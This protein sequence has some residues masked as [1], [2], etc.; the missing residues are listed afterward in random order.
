MIDVDYFRTRLPD[1]VRAMGR[2]V[3]VTVTLL[4]GSSLYVTRVASA[5][6]GY[7]VLEVFPL[8]GRKAEVRAGWREAQERGESIGE[9]D[10][11]TVAYEAIAYVAASYDAP[12]D[13]PRVGFQA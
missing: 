7:V 4:D 3:T 9:V 10:R 11:A 2:S 1:D 13:A 5:E 6:P 8:S 12:R